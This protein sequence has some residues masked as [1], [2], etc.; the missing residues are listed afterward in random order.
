MTFRVSA[1]Q[2]EQFLKFSQ[3]TNFELEQH[4]GQRLTVDAKPGFPCRVSLKD[5]EIGETVLL[6]N[7]F[8]HDHNTPYRASHAIFVR[9]N[10]CQAKPFTNIIPDVIKSRL[11]S[12]RGFNAAH[13][14]VTADV[15][16]G[17]GLCGVI[18]NFFDDGDIAYI[19]LHNAKQGCYAA[20]VDRA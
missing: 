18:N 15:V 2:A 9:E 16:G 20:R 1:L 14:M 19:H 7:F 5:A 17:N 3:M 4:G 6:L 13:D 12:V 10:A 8:H 11:I